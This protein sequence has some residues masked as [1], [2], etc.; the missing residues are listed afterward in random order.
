MEE[1]MKNRTL[2]TVIILIII[3]SLAAC[4]APSTPTTPPST[5]TTQ[6]PAPTTPPP[7][8][9][10]P[11]SIQIPPGILA[12]SKTDQKVGSL[13]T[14]GDI[15]LI[16]TEGSTIGELTAGES[17]IWNEHPTWSPDG[18][19]IAYHSDNA[20]SPNSSIW[21]VNADG[22]GK[23]KITEDSINGLWPSWSPDG[24]NIAFN[25]FDESGSKCKISLVNPDGSNFNTLTSGPNDLFPV[26]TPGGMIFF[27]RKI[28]TCE[29]ATGDV[30]AIQ[31]DGSGLKQ[32][33]K[34]GHVVGVGVSPDGKKIAYL[35][36]KKKQILVYRLDGSEPPTPIFDLPFIADFIQ[37]SWSP[38]GKTIAIASNELWT[39]YGS[40]LYL[41]NADGSGYF[42][43]PTDRGVFDPAW[44]PE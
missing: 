17:S 8:E 37:P 4:A 36:S 9:I 1:K 34:L 3:T 5:P 43:V 12:V 44:K 29:D 14:R 38:D 28:G 2:L 27:I 15:V 19:R 18:T 24:T 39:N 25:S 35:D 10:P 42:E 20:N 31:P 16:S 13:R 6:P 22:S 23:M 33:T 26:W 7:T 30:F 32:I 41:V 11:T 40:N 21:V